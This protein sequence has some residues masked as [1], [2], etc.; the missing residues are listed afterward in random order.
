MAGIDFAAIREFGQVISDVAKGKRQTRKAIVREVTPDGVLVE[1]G[2]S[3]VLTPVESS[4]ATYSVGDTVHVS[5]EGGRLHIGGDVTSPSVGADYVHEELAPVAEQAAEAAQ[6]ATAAVSASASAQ[7]AADEAEEVANAINQHFFDDLDGV[8]VTEADKDTW[9]A[10]HTGKNIL[11]NSLGILL[12]NALNNLVSI[13][14]SAIAFYDGLGNAASNIV[15]RFGATGAQI[16]KSDESHMEIDSVSIRGT[17]EDGY[18]F[19]EIDNDIDYANANIFSRLTIDNPEKGVT[20]EYDLQEAFSVMPSTGTLVYLPVS[21]TYTSGSDSEGA[22]GVVTFYYGTSLSGSIRVFGNDT[23]VATVTYSYDADTDTVS[24]SWAYSGTGFVFNWFGYARYV[25]DTKASAI[26][27]GSTRKQPT[28]KSIAVGEGL[29]AETNQIVVG[30]WNREDTNGKYAFIV[31]NGTAPWG[32]NRDFKDAF[33]IDWNGYLYRDNETAHIGSYLSAQNTSV[34]LPATG[35]VDSTV[36]GASITLTKGVWLVVGHA[37]FNTASTAGARNLHS[38]IWLD[39]SSQH[40]Q[41]VYSAASNYARLDVTTV[42]NVTSTTMT[43]QHRLA[44][45]HGSAA[46]N[47]SSYIVAVKLV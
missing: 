40:Y 4:A 18:S 47:N 34:T 19:F 13:T 23:P 46:N 2:G 30:K 1:I 31:G 41:R 6:I 22:D 8:H 11:V 39:G 21:S 36:V 12:R 24:L 37:I 35:N 3:G 29:T 17:N 27:V 9:N 45:S 5:N 43:A 38:A 10:S 33:A 25:A 20:Y 42:V 44:A 32:S 14:A 7:K 26:I 15:A 28:G 16:G